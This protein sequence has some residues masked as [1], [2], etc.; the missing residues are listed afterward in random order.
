MS[1]RAAPAVVLV[2]PQEAGNVG[3]AAR[4]MANMGLEEMIL[5]EPAPVLDR[6]AYAFAVGAHQILDTV[7]RRDSLREAL[8]PFQ[9]VVGTTS[10]RQRQVAQ[11]LIPA[12][13][14]AGKLAADAPG[15]RAALV[16]GPESSGL[17]TD[18]LALCDPLV[19]I[20]CSPAQP[21]LNL[22]QAVLIVAYELYLDEAPSVSAE[23]ATAATW[24]EVEQL[25]T[26]L[27][28]LCQGVGFAR[29]DTYGAVVRDLRRLAARGRPTGHEVQ[30]LHGLCRR[31][32]HALR[33][34]E[35]PSALGS[36]GPGE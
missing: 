19:T 4:A 7:G 32:L 15:S 9:R 34:G 30:I 1:K 27:D 28:K 6:T 23:P 33:R 5:V 25:F 31:T 20:P 22:S 11:H 18:E 16:F 10:T 24:D 21:T 35:S 2:R 8:A 14:L 13:D 12:R 3:A 36:D 26:H 29:D 17:D